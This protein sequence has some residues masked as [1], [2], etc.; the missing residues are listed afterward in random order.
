[1]LWNWQIIFV[2][3]FSGTLYIKWEFKNVIFL[4]KPHI[5]TFWF[6]V[7][8]TT[9]LRQDILYPLQT[10][11]KRTKPGPSFQLNKWPFAC[12][13]ILLLSVKLPKGP[14]RLPISITEIG[15][16][17]DFNPLKL[18][19]CLISADREFSIEIRSVADLKF[20]NLEIVNKTTNHVVF[21]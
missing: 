6:I 19:T 10:S 4:M 3:L 20:E 5:F 1:M 8:V 14:F 15:H 2:Y 13:T 16:W 9:L 18:V 21:I 7:I 17:S 11:A 12:C